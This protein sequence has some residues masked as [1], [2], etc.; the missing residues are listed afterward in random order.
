M[1]PLYECFRKTGKRNG[2]LPA[3]EYF[4]HNLDLKPGLNNLF[5]TF[6][7]DSVRRRIQRA[8]RAGLTEQCGR[9][10]VLLG[11]FYRLFVLTRQRQGVP[12][13]PYQ[14]FCNLVG[15]LGNALEIRL[16]YKGSMPI[17][18]ILTLRFRDVIYYKYGCSDRHFS[19]CGATPWLF[20]QAITAAKLSGATQFDFG[21]TEQNNPGLLAFKNH[22]VSDPKRIVYLQYPSTPKQDLA[23][24]W[25]GRLAKSVIP[26]MPSRLNVLVGNLLYRH[27]G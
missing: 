11:E 12:P 9:N 4:V 7:K 20:W 23:R 27:I 15:E 13:T 1:R 8:Q 14:W 18:G 26:L 5:D 16:A 3:D 25:K 2:W 22:W 17:A 24:G 10:E 6:D 21:R 19:G